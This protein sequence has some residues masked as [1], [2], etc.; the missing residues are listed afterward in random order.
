[1]TGRTVS[2]TST[3]T[4]VASVATDGT[5][6]ANAV[7]AANILGTADGVS[8]SAAITVLPATSAPIATQLLVSAQP[9]SATSG[10]SLPSAVVV[11][12]RDATGVTV[13]GAT[14]VVS[15]AVLSGGATL[16][17]TTSVAAVNGVATFT[18]LQLIGSGAQ[19]LG[20]SA[21]GL[22]STTSNAIALAGVGSITVTLGASPIAIAK[23]TMAT[24]T[25]LDAG[26]SV[27]AG[28]AVVW[29]S[30][31][32]AVATV[33]QDGTVTAV[34]AGTTNVSATSEGRT[35]TAMLTVQSGVGSV[36]VS[37][38]VAQV[39][40][41]VKTTASAIV[42]D[43]TNVAMTGRPIVWT[44]SNTAVASVAADGTVTGTGAGVA[45]I[46]GTADGVSGS[47]GITV[48]PAASGVPSDLLVTGQPSTATS[49]VNLS[50]AITVQVRDALGA[51]VPGATNVV[52]VGIA[53]GGGTVGGTT[54]VSAVAGVAT[55]FE[56]STYRGGHSDT[57]FAP[58]PTSV[59]P[60]RSSSP[61]RRGRRPTS[62]RTAPNGKLVYRDNMDAYTD[63]GR[64]AWST[65]GASPSAAP[66]AL[67]VTDHHVAAREHSA[68]QVVAPGRQGTGKAL[69]MSFP[70]ATRP[71]RAT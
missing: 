71:A 35:G 58:R 57:A 34:S 31:N 66:R 19:T 69:R 20:F 45:N 8:G 30:S 2:W 3:N 44:S 27:L 53:S 49:G 5:V 18:N 36:A 25:V 38:G 43:A 65:A 4:T 64:W 37:L 23:T 39:K 11:Q 42:R 70:G 32:P 47:A 46:V 61:Q 7:G 33:A 13:P 15:A 60:L 28:H 55:F 17:G 1:M 68:N 56:P 22:T 52:T 63:A 10:T 21:A 16:S 12:V 50:S 29:S 62:R 9:T 59:I 41:G 67:A 51:A 48:I 24:A 6:T 26:G 14:T 40:V 54:S